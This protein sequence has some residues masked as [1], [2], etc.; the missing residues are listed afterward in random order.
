MSTHASAELLSAYLDRQ[1]VEPEARQLEEHLDRC[2]QCHVRLEGLRKVVMHLKSMEQLATPLDLEQTVARR[3]ALA[4]DRESLLD[5]FEQSM[6]IFN[7]QSPIL[8]MFGVV[9]ALALFIYLF[10]YTLHLRQTAT[11]PVIWEDLPSSI[12]PA[13]ET[14]AGSPVA[15]QGHDGAQLAPQGH[16]GAQQVAGRTLVWSEDGLWVEE[17]LSVDS[18][19]RTLVL[20][21]EEGRAFL[22][23]H[24]ELAE[25]ATLGAGVVLAV[26]GEVVRLD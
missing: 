22:A 20:D 13:E 7:R 8:A 25:V 5:R 11:T 9:I 17:G 3:I 12:A 1:L 4:G 21:S 14:D 19:S 15:P 18:A 23:E 16:D 26:D 6:S 24:P 10:S 2:S